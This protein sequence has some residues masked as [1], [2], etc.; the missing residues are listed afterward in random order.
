MQNK[1]YIAHFKQLHHFS[2]LPSLN[3][4]ISVESA[5][6]SHTAAPLSMSVENNSTAELLHCFK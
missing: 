2:P 3:I 5:N 6:I 4:S 1:V